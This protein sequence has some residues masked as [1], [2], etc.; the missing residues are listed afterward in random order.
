MFFYVSGRFC[1]EKF[2]SFFDLLFLALR[3]QSVNTLSH[4]GFHTFSLWN[5]K[6]NSE[7]ITCT[8]EHPLVENMNA[9]NVLSQNNF[10]DKHTCCKKY[11]ASR[12]TVVCFK[13]LNDVTRNPIPILLMQFLPAFS[14]N[15][16]D[17]NMMVWEANCA[18][19]LCHLPV[20]GGLVSHDGGIIHWHSSR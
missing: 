7:H 11:T 1:P 10:K 2:D 20:C 12:C 13:E 4:W 18:R 8:L 15:K 16:V 6:E 3:D 17:L 19:R 5:P 14:R 9:Y